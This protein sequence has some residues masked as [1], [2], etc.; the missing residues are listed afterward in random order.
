MLPIRIDR[1]SAGQH[2]ELDQVN[3]I[4]K[5]GRLRIRALIVPLAAECGMVAPEIDTVG[6]LHEDTVRAGSC[7]VRLRASRA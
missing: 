1:L 6:R 7:A 4:A 5:D 3:A 2:A